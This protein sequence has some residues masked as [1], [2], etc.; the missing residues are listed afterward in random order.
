MSIFKSS[1]K[2]LIKTTS[3]LFASLAMSNFFGRLFLDQVILNVRNKTLS[4]RHHE[5]DFEFSVPNSL[6]FYRVNTFS[7]KEPETLEWIDSIPQNAILWDVG[8]NIGLYSC[9]AAKSKNCRVYA[10]EPS[11]LNMELLARNISLNDL[12]SMVTIVPLPLTDAISTSTLNMT[13]MEWGGALST[14]GQGYG[15]DGLPLKVVFSFSTIGLSMSDAAKRLNVPAPNYIKIDVDGIEALIL[16]GGHEILSNVQSVLIEINE[17]FEKQKVDS[18]HYLTNAGLSLVKR[19][20][21]DK[22][23][24]ISKCYNQIW[25]REV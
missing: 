9:Y 6:N 12:A 13:T 10:F 23:S 18:Y 22:S 7:T 16:K 20:S 15:H 25:A 14:F 1:A 11:V 24:S 2:S 17:G 5:H 19:C 3:Y 8:A 21:A 4:V